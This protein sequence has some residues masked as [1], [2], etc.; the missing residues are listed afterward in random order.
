MPVKKANMALTGAHKWNVAANVIN[1]TCAF[2]AMT[3]QDVC[4]VKGLQCGNL[5]VSLAIYLRLTLSG[6]ALM[7]HT[8]V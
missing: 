6:L 1:Y 5:S 3:C 8:A 7:A 2:P 4:H